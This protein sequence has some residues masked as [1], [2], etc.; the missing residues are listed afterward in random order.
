MHNIAAWSQKPTHILMFSWL[1][2]TIGLFVGSLFWGGLI[3]ILCMIL[4]VFFAKGWYK[5]VSFVPSV[6]VVGVL[7]FMVLLFYC[8]FIVGEMRHINTAHECKEIITQQL[9]TIGLSDNE[10]ISKAE[11]ASV[12]DN[13]YSQIP[14]L[15]NYISDF[16]FE[17]S[18]AEL[19]DS[20]I[21][22]LISALRKEVI[23]DVVKCLVAFVAAIAIVIFSK[24]NHT[25][26]NNYGNMGNGDYRGTS[27]SYTSS[28]DNF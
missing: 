6:Y 24:P 20:M 14:F 26:Y 9:N 18:V 12:F 7:L 10:H 23:Y 25:G 19:P 16:S 11:L 2:G 5:N 22:Q 17:G 4:F 15:S 27:S 8:T 3:T 21:N 1:L 13:L 28:G